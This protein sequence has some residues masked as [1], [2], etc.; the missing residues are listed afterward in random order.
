MSPFVSLNSDAVHRS[1]AVIARAF[2][3]LFS[4]LLFFVTQRVKRP[5]EKTSDMP[6][7][8]RGTSGYLFSVRPVDGGGGRRSPERRVDPRGPSLFLLFRNASLSLLIYWLITCKYTPIT[9][10]DKKLIHN[11]L[12]RVAR[13]GLLRTILTMSLKMSLQKG[14]L[15][16]TSSRQIKM[17]TTINYFREARPDEAQ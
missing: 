15:R 6:E 7:R 12:P 11:T 17:K 16:Y 10:K 8:E 2:S 9:R 1:S 4:L 13:L 3:P 5:T 14:P